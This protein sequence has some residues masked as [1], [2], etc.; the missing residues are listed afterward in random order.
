MRSCAPPSPPARLPTLPTNRPTLP[1]RP[2]TH[3]IPPHPTPPHAGTRICTLWTRGCSTISPR[4]ALVRGGGGAAGGTLL[5]SPPP[6]APAPPLRVT[7]V[8]L[9]PLTSPP[10]YPPTH[11]QTA[12]MARSMCLTLAWPSDQVGVRTGCAR[13]PAVPPRRTPRCVCAP[14]AHLPHLP[15]PLT[16][17]PTHPLPLHA[18]THPPP[19]QAPT[20]SPTSPPRC[21]AR[22][23]AGGRCFPTSTAP[24]WTAT[25]CSSRAGSAG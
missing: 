21:P 25:S 2:P 22:C 13:A 18:C 14:P 15:H 20:R 12:G 24:T 16:R 23:V 8:P 19:P 10:P 1:A 5:P 11:S 3:P 7:T 6:C 9:F 4:R 17:P